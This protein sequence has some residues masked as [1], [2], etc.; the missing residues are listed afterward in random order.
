M[1]AVLIDVLFFAAGFEVLTLVTIVGLTDSTG[2]VA[3]AAVVCAPASGLPGEAGAGFVTGPTA[4]TRALC[5]EGTISAVVSADVGSV[6]VEDPGIDA[7][8]EA[9]AAA[10]SILLLM[11]GANGAS[12]KARERNR[13]S[14]AASVQH[15]ENP[16]GELARRSQV[17][18]GFTDRQ[19]Q[20]DNRIT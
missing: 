14:G 2:E 11:M 7:V 19:V 18:S 20:W 17:A 9:A 4:S 3:A 10:V 13:L 6:P 8:A 5:A 12:S 16:Q 15:D 1:L